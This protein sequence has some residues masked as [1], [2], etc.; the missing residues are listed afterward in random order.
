MEHVSSSFPTF[1]KRENTALEGRVLLPQCF[2]CFKGKLGRLGDL[3]RGEA[4]LQHP[5]RSECDAFISPQSDAFI[6]PQS[7]TPG[8]HLVQNTQ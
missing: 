6:S 8:L 4:Q 7:D 1:L 3:L 5:P 2:D